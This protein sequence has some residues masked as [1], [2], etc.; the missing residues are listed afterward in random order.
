MSADQGGEVSRQR[1]HPGSYSAVSPHGLMITRKGIVRLGQT[2]RNR[3]I[4]AELLSPTS[5]GDVGLRPVPE[6]LPLS[7]ARQARRNARN[8]PEVPGKVTLVGEACNERNF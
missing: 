3:Y 7:P 1:D 2:G 6:P 8:S 4:L 5:A